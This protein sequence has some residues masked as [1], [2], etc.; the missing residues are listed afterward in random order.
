MLMFVIT[1]PKPLQREIADFNM[2]MITGKLSVLTLQSNL[3][4]SI[5]LHQGKDSFLLKVQ[6]FGGKN[7]EFK[8][9]VNGVIYFKERICVPDFEFIKKQILS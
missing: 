3:L 1:S 8:T 2:E 6:L 7:K 4:E 9:S 5:K